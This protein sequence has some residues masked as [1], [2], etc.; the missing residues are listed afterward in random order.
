MSF[1]SD[2]SLLG[3]ILKNKIQIW[4]TTKLNIISNIIFKNIE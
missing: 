4:D 3:V 1:A 2:K